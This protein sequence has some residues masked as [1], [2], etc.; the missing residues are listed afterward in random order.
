MSSWRSVLGRIAGNVENQFETLK[1]RLDDRIGHEPIAIVPYLGYGTAT[2]IVIKGRVLEQTTI[3]EATDND[4]VWDNVLNMYRRFATDEVPGARVLARIAN[5]EHEITSDSEGYFQATLTPTKPLSADSPWHKV[6][7]T[8]LA[9]QPPEAAPVHTVGEV[10]VP[11]PMAQFGIISD[12]DDTV[13]KTDATNLLRMARTVFLGNARTRL[14][15]PGVAALYRAL[16]TGVPGPFVNPLFFV[17]SSPWNIYDMLI[18]FFELKGIPKAPLFL[19]DWGISPDELPFGHRAHKLE[20]IRAVIDFYP[21]L[22]FLLIGDSGQEDP[23]I[24]SEIVRLYPQ[25]ILAVYIRSVDPDPRRIEAI[26]TLTEQVAAAGCT[27]I[28]ADDTLAMAQHAASNGWITTEA[29]AAVAAEKTVDEGEKGVVEQAL[30]EAEPTVV[31]SGHQPE[32][33]A[34][35]VAEQITQAEQQGE[36]PP[37]I[38]VPPET[39]QTTGDI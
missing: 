15:F 20:S 6:E 28:L 32:K 18:D 21:S 17:S 29:L 24:Y 39:N 23:E 5:T 14:P 4:S 19:R 33:A 36:Q 7:L 8:L 9:P 37:T 10:F 22:R 25:R 38:V 12:I 1:R 26:R 11:Q 13:V 35:T 2:K 31:I 3:S 30:D 27:L 34:N 16:H